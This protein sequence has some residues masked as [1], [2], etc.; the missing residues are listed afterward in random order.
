VNELEK[1]H[2]REREADKAAAVE[3]LDEA[4]SHVEAQGREPDQWERICLARAFQMMCS[5]A[6]GATRTEAV[7][8]LTPPSDRIPSRFF[9]SDPIFDEFNLTLLK[10]LLRQARNAPVEPFA[11]LGPVIF[12]GDRK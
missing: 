4:I 3:A 12:T 1:R 6:Y 2:L 8:A 5:N 9:P 11:R 10:D 7:L